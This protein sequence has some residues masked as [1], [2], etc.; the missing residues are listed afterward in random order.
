[1]KITRR[2]FIRSALVLFA[3][4]FSYRLSSF[5]FE[6]LIR[7]ADSLK[8]PT[9]PESD[10]GNFRYIYLNPKLKEAFY[11]FLQNVFHLF[12]EKEFHKL[13]GEVSSQYA[14]DREIYEKIQAALPKIKPFL[15]SLT[16]ALP[17]LRKQKQEMARQTRVLLDG[18]KSVKGYLEIGTTGRYISELRHSLQVKGPVYLINDLAPTYAPVDLMERGQLVKYGKFIPLNDYAP[19][20]ADIPEES[21]DLVTNF[22]GFHHSPSDRLDGFVR[23]IAKVLKPGGRLIVRDHDVDSPEMNRIVALAHDVFDVGLDISWKLNHEQIR[24]FW[25]RAQLEAY[26]KERGFQAQAP[27]LLQEGDP[28]RNTLVGFVKA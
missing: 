26:L 15:S 18:V 12:P 4:T 13:I 11:P 20:P 19:F 23:S 2:D 24:N 27:Q 6:S 16:Y 28:T 22:I 1:M 10:P 14:T 8:S 7:A 3:Y 5:D 9:S 21:L 25:S 17:A